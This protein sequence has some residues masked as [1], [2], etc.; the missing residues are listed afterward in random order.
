[1]QNQSSNE[2]NIAA[3]SFNLSSTCFETLLKAILFKLKHRLILL[4]VAKQIL[5]KR[6]LGIR[7]EASI[8]ITNLFKGIL[9][10]FTLVVKIR[11]E[12]KKMKDKTMINAIISQRRNANK[13][14]QLNFMKHLNS[15]RYHHLYERV[16]NCYSIY[17]SFNVTD[18]SLMMK[19]FLQNEWELVKVGYCSLRKEYVVDIPKSKVFKTRQ[20]NINY[21]ID[22]QVII[23]STLL[24]KC[25]N[26]QFVNVIDLDMIEKKQQLMKK[27]IFDCI[28]DY[29]K[30]RRKLSNSESRST[31]ADEFHF[32]EEDD[33]SNEEVYWTSG[34]NNKRRNTVL[35]TVKVNSSEMAFNLSIRSQKKSMT[36]KFDLA[37]VKSI[38]KPCNNSKTSKRC[39]NSKKVCFGE[40]QFSF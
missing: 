29:S 11:K 12:M 16:K 4:S 17:P 26:G 31:N 38:L 21:L 2:I 35:K 8:T 13:L 18:D 32:E 15:K 23:D 33:G 28:I 5:T 30:K 3:N 6:I 37:N 22:D 9:I 40:V 10:M 19:I 14:I 39:L 24:A 27:K 20:L 25:E 36:V 1:M 34:T 7:H